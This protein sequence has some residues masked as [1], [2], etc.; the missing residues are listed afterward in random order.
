MRGVFATL[1]I[2][3]KCTYMQDWQTLPLLHV[4]HQLT[5]FVPLPVQQTKVE[6]VSAQI[7]II[8]RTML[9]K[10]SKK[11]SNPSK[12]ETWTGRLFIGRLWRFVCILYAH[13]QI[14]TKWMKP[15]WQVKYKSYIPRKR[16]HDATTATTTSLSNPPWQGA[17]SKVNLLARTNLVMFSMTAIIF[18][19]LQSEH[20]KLG[21]PGFPA[22]A[23]FG[24]RNTYRM[25]SH[26]WSQPTR[27]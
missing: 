26:N 21:C 22:E 5:G 19:A 9:G 24:D 12:H 14:Y 6:T 8:R 18:L 17:V 7:S 13:I 27:G 2:C 25:A 15:F 4:I 10:R 3:I 23:P 16:K 11:L 20:V 1:K